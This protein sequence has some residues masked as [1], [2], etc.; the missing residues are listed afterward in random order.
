MQP[1]MPGPGTKSTQPTYA[2][3]VKTSQNSAATGYTSGFTG[4][5]SSSTCPTSQVSS[6]P[7]LTSTGAWDQPESGPDKLNRDDEPL[8]GVD[9]PVAGEEGELSESEEKQEISEDM[10]HRETVRFVCAFM[11]CNF[12]G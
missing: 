9:I 7:A 11:G 2:E 5:T 1:V 6:L 3:V 8:F 4:S 12:I 10:N